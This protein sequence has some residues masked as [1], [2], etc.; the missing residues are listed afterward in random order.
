[1]RKITFLILLAGACPLL[2]EDTAFVQW[3]LHSDTQMTE[4]GKKLRA[5]VHENSQVFGDTKGVTFFVPMNATTADFEARV[6]VALKHVAGKPNPHLLVSLISHGDEHAVWRDGFNGSYPLDGIVLALKR[7]LGRRLYNGKAIPLSLVYDACY[8][9]TIFE[10]LRKH[11]GPEEGGRYRVLAVASSTAAKVSHGSELVAGLEN[12]VRILR[13][14][15]GPDPFLSEY[16]PME[17]LAMITTG[18]VISKNDEPTAWSSA[19]NLDRWDTSSLKRAIESMT[20]PASLSRPVVETFR[21][22]R[23]R[24]SSFPSFAVF[25]KRA[26]LFF[27]A[28]TM[29]AYSIDSSPLA[30]RPAKILEWILEKRSL[31]EAAWAALVVWAEGLPENYVDKTVLAG[32][33]APGWMGW[34]PRRLLEYKAFVRARALRNR[35]AYRPGPFRSFAEFLAAMQIDA[36]DFGEAIL[37]VDFCSHEELEGRIHVL[38]KG[39]LKGSR[40]P[41]LLGIWAEGLPREWMADELVEEWERE[42]RARTGASEGGYFTQRTAIYLKTLV[43]LEDAE[44]LL[45]IYAATP[46]GPEG[47]TESSLHKVVRLRVARYIVENGLDTADAIATLENMMEEGYLLTP[48]QGEFW[49]RSLY[50]RIPSDQILALAV[51]YGWVERLVEKYRYYPSVLTDLANRLA[52]LERPVCARVE[53]A[54]AGAD[55]KMTQVH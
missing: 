50:A 1:M 42:F 3:I 31:D 9:G 24:D 22:D 34:H 45:A 11:F 23:I 54:A 5:L 35:I 6:E 36:K 44:G 8:S 14:V 2:A 7:Q 48:Q 30:E 4:K 29:A 18:L 28:A 33:A 52:L 12:S 26:D 32:K 20:V 47:G 27:G 38:M 51:K 49:L 25:L 10:A 19:E 40:L 16:S 53:G 41:F 13:R 43:H 15:E 17:K 37:A 39:A 55:G 21:R 46:R